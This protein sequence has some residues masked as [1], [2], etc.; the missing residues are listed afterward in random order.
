M[1][2]AKISVLAAALLAAAGCS[3]TDSK[4]PGPLPT[5]PSLER[6][7]L[8]AGPYD[9]NT[10]IT[11]TPQGGSTPSGAEPS[12][13]YAWYVNG[14]DAGVTADE[15]TG[16][17]FSR[18]DTVQTEVV[19]WDGDTAGA[20]TWSKVVTIDNA[21]PVV[22][23][24]DL[25]AGP[26]LETST[27]TATVAAVDADPADNPLKPANMTYDWHVN[28]AS[29]RKG[30]GATFQTL[31]GAA[32]DK[33]DQV[34]VRVT[35][36]DGIDESE[37]VASATV[38]IGNSAPV[39]TSVTL[40]GVAPYSE[41]TTA[42][43]AT[44]SA[45]DADGDGLTFGFQ[46]YVNGVP[47]STMATIANTAY[48][49]NDE[50]ALAVT[51]SDGEATSAPLYAATI[52][53]LNSAP[54]ITSVS[55]GSGPFYNTSTLTAGALGV[56]DPDASD[57][58]SAVY[59]WFVNGL[60]VASTASISSGYAKGDT[61]T[62]AARAYDGAA[63][64]GY[65]TAPAVTIQNRLP[66][67]DSLSITPLTAYETSTFNF[68]AT[69]SDDDGDT[70]AYQRMWYVNGSAN[71]V[72]GTTLTGA[73]FEHGDTVYLRITPWDGTQAGTPLD[74]N[75]VTILN[76]APALASAT[77]TS[78]GSPAYGID[79]TFYVD[80]YTGLADADPADAPVLT[81]QWYVAGVPAVGETGALLSGALLTKGDTVYV[82]VT[83][84]D[85]AAYGLAVSSN[86][87]AIVNTP[88][89]ISSVGFGSGPFYNTSTLTAAALGVGDADTG[90]VPSAE[91][92]W[93]VNGVAVASTASINTG[94]ARG[95]TVTVAA[96][97]FDGAAYSGFVTAPVVTIQNR[98]PVMDSVS[99]TPLT[100]YETSTFAFTSASHDDDGDTVTYQR[101]WYVNSAASGITAATLTGAA[102]A[103][104]DAVF[105]RIVPFDGADNGN[106][107]DS[108]V[109]VVQNSVPTQ[110]S[111]TLEPQAYTAGDD[112]F[113]AFSMAST[114][115]DPID[116]VTYTYQWFKNGVD[117]SF[118][119]ATMGVVKA[120]LTAGDTWKVVVTPTDGY[121]SGPT[122]WSAK[123]IPASTRSSLGTGRYN[124]TATPLPNGKVLLAG[125][126]GSGSAALASAE[127]YDPTTD[128]FTPTGSMGAARGNHTATL[129]PNGKVLVAGGT[130]GGA[131]AE[132][133]DPGTG[134]FTPTGSMST[135]RQDHTATLL[136]NGLLL[137]VGGYTP[138]TSNYLASAELYDPGTGTFAPTGSMGAARYGHTATLLADGKVLIA[139]SHNT[140]AGYLA[141]AELYDPGAGTFT[142]TGS[143]GAARALHTA[144]LLPNGKVL[145]AGGFDGAAILASAE[146]Y[147]PDAGTFA[148]TGSMGAARMYHTATLLPNGGVLIAGGYSIGGTALASAE[149]YE[150]DWGGFIPALSFAVGRGGHTATLLPN[151][152]MLITGGADMSA[153]LSDPSAE[154]YEP[155]TG[156]FSPT[157]S[158]GTARLYHT[159]T[160][161]PNGLMLLAGG[162]D[163][164]NAALASAELYDPTTDTFTPT[165]SMG[166][167][168]IN[169][170]ATLLPDG[171]VLITGGS[172][173]GASAELYNPTTGTFTPTGSMGSAREE[174]T[175]ILLP[176]GKVLVAGG[177]SW[178]PL[179]SAELYDPETGVFT[180]TG[181]MGTARQVPR[182]TLLPNGKVLISG[183]YVDDAGWTFI[184]SA[185]LYDPATGT[186]TPTGS[187]STARAHHTATLLPNGKVLVAGGW[188]YDV[189]YGYIS[190]ATSEIYDPATGVF[191][192]TGSMA[193]VR[194]FHTATLLPNGR[195]LMA[196]GADYFASAATAGAEIYDPETGAFH[197]AW[198][199]ADA[200]FFHTATL[201]D[202]G[203]V[204]IAGGQDM[205]GLLAGVELYDPDMPAPGTFL[206]TGGLVAGRYDH[207]STLL[208]NGLVLMAGGYDGAAMAGA[209]LYDPSAG[210]FATTNSMGA[211]RQNHTATLL[212]NGEVLIAGGIDGAASA[213]LYDP[214]T[215]TFVTTGAM[216]AARKYHTATLLPNGNVLLTGGSDGGAVLASAELYYPSAGT[217]AATGSMATARYYHTATL[218]PNGLVLIAGGFG[219]A[220]LASAELYDPATGVFTP[221]GSLVMSRYVHTA[222]MLPTGKVLFAGGYDTAN[223]TLAS[224]ELYD[225]VTETFMATGALGTA[226]YIHTATLL[227]S[228]KVLIAGGINGAPLWAAELYDPVGGV[229]GPTGTL[230][231]GRYVHTATPLPDGSVLIAGGYGMGLL[232]SAML[233][234]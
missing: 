84:Y 46:W 69:S 147:D 9:E 176:N 203:K 23:R 33:G 45:T 211:A 159:A 172:G 31:D 34:V 132:L 223:G 77:I 107:L 124:H 233:Y 27:L 139:G 22:E 138:S 230:G 98:L 167:A 148:P 41:L 49:K 204:L 38:T 108:N 143:M 73:N 12:Y 86:A 190:F 168:R 122:A 145:V 187:M 201:L 40:S 32:F 50:I 104:G 209:E 44:P 222:T 218:L 126:L 199:L 225:P 88:P 153:V 14:K 125:G 71:G 120:L 15:L 140:G 96:R 144:T 6:V 39:M 175:A 5:A 83:P 81:Y 67:M 74:S 25:S 76:S 100:A 219:A 58:P 37:I 183:G 157:G 70:V 200:R 82:L 165:G 113:V 103:H 79:A 151:G 206:E 205:A 78:L 189:G 72:T 173:G 11:A 43:T 213:E 65:V 163:S 171:K 158:P 28:G 226:R 75:T 130:G 57:A 192:P 134:T 110:P 129:L 127:L 92:R 231:S 202:N 109:V 59:R 35:Y 26:Y 29:V 178:V 177:Y 95:D 227:P 53:I 154:L 54:T 149:L 185:E 179:A 97:A 94:Y 128:T 85:G 166:A 117:Q 196:G 133:Y 24:V 121:A 215:S 47:A 207:S 131:S 195:V 90:D 68:T 111:I 1:Q 19:P 162:Q 123:T 188:G 152:W 224:A 164:G 87:V 214:A 42:I 182:A 91:Y 169:H 146:L 221:T 115:A 155:G 89:T 197:G 137:I 52:T 228:G 13:R 156:T 210:T 232:Q 212:P 198:F 17:D 136:P 105:L 8:S 161:L 48:A 7:A 234:R 229:F 141:S 30:A 160:L 191:T 217:F 194:A 64:S 180:P 114:D 10:T 4:Q 181:L 62:V 20:P 55:F 184:A 142:P 208:P 93:F 66:V 170:T 216:V 116:T 106:A 36:D 112:L 16:D 220:A 2:F 56:A 174:H 102:F 118:A 18:G 119:A 60:L 193:A 51:A 61:V 3:E 63:Y 101:M 135:G 150:A 99:I 21:A 80:G 186:F